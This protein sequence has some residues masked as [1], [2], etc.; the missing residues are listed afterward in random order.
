MDILNDKL[1]RPL[2]PISM[3]ENGAFLALRANSTLILGEKGV[4]GRGGFFF[5]SVQDCSS[6][7]GIAKSGQSRVRFKRSMDEGFLHDNDEGD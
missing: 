6:E 3:M 7:L 2:L 1:R 4:G 5:Y